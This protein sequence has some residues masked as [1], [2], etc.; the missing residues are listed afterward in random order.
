MGRETA[1][2]HLGASDQRRPILRDLGQR[3][4]TWLIKAARAM[5]EATRAD[6]KQWRSRKAA[7]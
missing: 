5:A 6:W 1:N 3:K 4:D 7:A 2:I